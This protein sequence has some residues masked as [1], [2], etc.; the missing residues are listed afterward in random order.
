M[1]TAQMKMQVKGCRDKEGTGGHYLR[2]GVPGA[3]DSK[4]LLRDKAAPS[5]P[6]VSG[7][8]SR[9]LLDKKL[10]SAGCALRH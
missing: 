1:K 2:P 3:R 9:P 8:L 4:G 6:C 7:E 5:I 10:M